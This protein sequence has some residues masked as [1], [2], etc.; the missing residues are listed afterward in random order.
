MQTHS[1]AA[2]LSRRGALSGA[3]ALTVLP[4]SLPT[5]ARPQ[6][7]VPLADLPMERCVLEG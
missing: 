1:Q 3:V 5:H 4:R 2:C 6:A 7:A